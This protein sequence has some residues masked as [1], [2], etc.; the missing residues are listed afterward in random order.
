MT[1]V[2]FSDGVDTTSRDSDYLKSIS[3]ARESNVVISTT[4]YNSRKDFFSVDFRR[5]GG[6]R[7]P[8]LLG[9]R[10]G[11]LALEQQPKN[12]KL[13]DGT[14]INPPFQPEVGC[15]TLALQTLN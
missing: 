1:I 6:I 4:Y 15:L 11:E 13:A 2:L 3:D 14:C 8:I 9:G 5:S 10:V 12:T 7:C